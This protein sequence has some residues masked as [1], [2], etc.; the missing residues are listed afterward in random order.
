M[1]MENKID[2]NQKHMCFIFIPQK[3]DLIRSFFHFRKFKFKCP[4]LLTSKI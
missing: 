3:T 4:N 2:V 1:N